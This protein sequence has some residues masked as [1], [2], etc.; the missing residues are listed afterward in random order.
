MNKLLYLIL[1]KVISTLIGPLNYER[2]KVCV[3]EAETTGLAGDMKVRW[4]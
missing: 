1:E 4:C 2:L 3:R